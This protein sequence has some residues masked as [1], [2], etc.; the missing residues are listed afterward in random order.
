MNDPKRK[1]AP[2]TKA[3]LDRT[4]AWAAEHEEDLQRILT[5]HL[6]EIMKGADH[7]PKL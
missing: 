6:N 1:P 7:G 5:E 3:I 4:L 2:F